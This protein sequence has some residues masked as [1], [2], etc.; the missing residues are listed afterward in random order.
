MSVLVTL[1]VVGSYKDNYV[2]GIDAPR[3]DFVAFYTDNFARV[4]LTATLTVWSSVLVLVFFISL[5]HFVNAR[6]DLLGSLAI[7]L[8]AAATAVSVAGQ[9][10]FASPTLVFEMTDAKI[11]DNLDSGVARALIMVP[12]SLDAV[13]GVLFGFAFIA[14]GIR[15]FGSDIA[16]RRFLGITAGLMGGFGAVNLMLGGGGGFIT[17]ILWTVPAAV[18]VLISRSRLIRPDIGHSD[19]VGRAQ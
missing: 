13:G 19:V 4:R 17:I 8:A 6:F 5:M 15:I 18:L 9:A 14:L 11:A 7:T 1:L 3:D 10:L 2:P 16:G 12:D